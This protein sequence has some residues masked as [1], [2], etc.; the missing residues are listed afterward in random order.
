MDLKRF[1]ARPLCV[2]AAGLLTF[3][4]AACSDNDSDWDG[5]SD[6]ETALRLVVADYTANT[7]IPTYEALADA[8]VDLYNAI[9]AMYQAGA[10]HVTEAQVK[11]AGD[12]WRVAR[13]YW[14]RSEAWLYGPA[15]DYDVDPHIDSWPLNAT[16]LQAL[17]N[18]S[19]E[20]AKMDAEGI[21]ISQT[22]DYGILG[23]HA[24]EYLLFQ[25][26]GTGMSQTSV[27]HATNYT[28]E[29][30]SYITGVAGD[31]RNQ[32][33]ILEAAW[34]GE[35]NISQTK[36]NILD[37]V[38][39][40]GET[41]TGNNENWSKALNDLAAGLCYADEMKNPVEGS[42]SDFVNF[43]AAAQTMITDGIQ[44]IANEVGNV[45]I[46]NPTG[47]GSGEDYEYDPGYI[48]SPYSL[49]SINDFQGNIISIEN[50]YMG[51]QSG[52]SYNA[53]ETYIKASTHTLSA[54]V[55]TFN[56]ELDNR[57]KA[58]ITAAYDAIGQMAEPF[59]YTCNSA[60]GYQAQNRAAITACN[61]LNDIFDEVLRALQEQR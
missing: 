2:A 22:M 4:M 41:M 9:Y 55:A 34:R 61:E 24:L 16:A 49:N 54:Y 48:E 11:A 44:N 25:V 60:N 59:A 20:M 52:K 5:T 50:A 21:Y 13:D 32:C 14:E 8:S 12:A 43:L 45:K 15:G 40:T 19:T 3:G 53:G 6:R 35:S 27:P 37:K 47:M 39:A 31:L 1:F 28:T 30:L 56:P 17:L 51:F 36:Q 58:A 33:I 29:E 7:V 18:N 10:G 26:E 46:G 38:R 42:S 23:F 57:V